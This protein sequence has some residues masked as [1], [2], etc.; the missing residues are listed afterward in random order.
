M[1]KKKF[2]FLLTGRE[3]NDVAAQYFVHSHGY[4]EEKCVFYKLRYAPPYENFRGIRDFERMTQYRPFTDPARK[5][6]AVAIDLSEWITHEKEEYLEIFFKFL[7]DYNWSFYSFE[8]IFTVG[9][10]DREKAKELYKLASE[11]LCEGA[12]VEDRTLSDEKKMTGYLEGMYSVAHTVAEKLAHILVSNE[13]KGYAQL[14]TV[15]DDFAKHILLYGEG[16][17]ITEEQ[18][19][20]AFDSLKNSKL[21]IL[22]EKD[23]SAWK[24]EAE[25]ERKKEIERGE[26]A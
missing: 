5:K 18:V 25:K 15:V 4:R 16:G 3:D 19:C 6:A 17:L 23:L 8:Y 13:I 26:A 7:H 21:G 11:Y 22:Y 1:D 2:T 14:K 9:A 20:K 10:A 24:T 12:L